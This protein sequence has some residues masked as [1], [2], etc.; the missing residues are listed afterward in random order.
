M[1][2]N[3]YTHFYFESINNLGQLQVSNIYPPTFLINFSVV[4]I[5]N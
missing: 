4:K 3:T 5:W 2:I 1:Y